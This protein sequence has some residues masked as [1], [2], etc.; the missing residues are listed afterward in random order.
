MTST[1][2]S[3]VVVSRQ[4]P[5]ALI[6]CLTGISQVRYAPFEI[7]VVADPSGLD[8]VR[9]WPLSATVKTIAFNQPNIAMA[10]NLGIETAAGDVIAFID[11]DAVPEP[12]WLHHLIAP[13]KDPE[14]AASGGFVRGR[15]GISWQWRAFSVDLAGQIRSLQVS[16]DAPVVLEPSQGRAIK[17]E[18]TNMAI[19]RSVLQRLGGF[20]S[21][22]HYFLDETDLNLRLAK[23]GASTAVA[24]MAV[25]HHGFAGNAV[26]RED[27]APRDLRQVGASWAVFL[28]KHCPDT[29][30]AERWAQ[31][32]AGERTRL[33][34]YMVE[35]RLEP[36]DVRR[37][38]KGLK[39]GYAEGLSRTPSSTAP[40]GNDGTTFHEFP[41]DSERTLVNISGRIW[42][43]RRLLGRAEEAARS[44]KIACVYMLS[45]TTLRHTRK[46]SPQGY[47][48]QRGGLFGKSLRSDQPFK[49]WR[50]RKR[51]ARE[52]GLW[53][54]YQ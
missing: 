27:R 33:V 21:N 17:T 18:G 9:R 20:D 29:L 51:V 8:A 1:P 52:A 12:G 14:V 32:V 38:L 26:R 35:G 45:P 2:V 30:V 54:E 7:I 49:W 28:T 10:R 53:S 31:I 50:F 11:D 13:F 36:R 19:R 37:M 25:V 22:F 5:E 42:S 24:P 46:Y 44:G 48:L 34:K 40:L 23:I 4:R 3:V 43:K 6:R 47:W 41:S 15:N 16:D 39:D